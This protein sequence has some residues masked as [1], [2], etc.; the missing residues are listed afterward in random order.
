MRYMSFPRQ[1]ART[2][3]FTLGAPRS[4]QI[5][6]DGTRAA[7]LRSRSGND[8]ATC[9]WVRE[10]G[11]H[12]EWVAADPREL[13]R[14]DEDLPPE[15]RAR[16]ERL[17]ETG[18][19][20]VSY[21]VDDAFT[22]AVFTLSG[23]LY[24]VDLAGGDPRE[25]P[26]A[27]PVVD[28]VLCPRG[29]S[30]AYVSGGAVHV[31]ALGNGADL[32]LAEP[33]GEHVTW[34]LADFIASEEMGRYHGMWWSP[35]SSAVLAARVDD[36]AVP[37]W[38]IADPAHPEAAARTI[39]YPAAGTENADVRLAILPADGEGDRV[40]I[41][42]NRAALPYLV[43]AGWT[44][45]PEGTPTVVFSA[46][47]RDQRT[48]TVF[49]ADPVTGLVFELH[50]ETDEVW[51][52]IM[53]GV[54][55]FCG[56]ALLWI[57][58]RAGDRER[59]LYLGGDAVTPEGLYLRGVVSVDGDRVLFSASESGA[60]EST[61]LWLLDVKENHLKPVEFP[62]S[63]GTGGV[64]AGRLRGDT[65]VHQRRDLE[66]DGVVT[67]VTQGASSE[68]R[69]VHT[70]VTSHAETPDLPTPRVTMWRAGER[71]IPAALVLPSW[72]EPGSGRLP[73]LLDPYGGPHAQRVVSAR[74]AFLTSQW[75]ADQGFAVLIADGRGTPGIGVQW[76][77][78]VHGDL[79]GPVLE[80]QVA[81]LHDALERY[82]DLDPD[83]VAIRGWSFGG[84]LAALAV[85]R[86]PDVFH[87]AISGAPVTD[88]RLYDTHYTERYL[89]HPAT[90]V[91]AY[92]RSSVIDDAAHLEGRL[93]LI[94][95]YVDDNVVYAHTQRLSS[96][97]LAAGKAHTVLP[98]SGI[99]HMASEE[100]TAENLLLL[101]VAFLRE[102][103]PSGAAADTAVGG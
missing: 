45:G 24:C 25:L 28:P 85:L 101:Q 54:P 35:D 23:R 70:A 37:R 41:E 68:T 79:A 88:Q 51:V 59:R 74:S 102:T 87:A 72:Y 63:N 62:T 29:E 14:V 86:R 92:T 98:L 13:G 93:M 49:S 83:R 65:L 22:R 57:G 91:A 18:S 4:F 1:Q 16:R 9:L 43:T 11:G 73:V 89:G 21:T 2:R 78:A 27:T 32:T 20:I 67:M 76:E 52:E 39:A 30:V 15:E 3:R 84:F 95:G 46:Q 81:V 47:S 26:A 80:D 99:T 60:P 33:D 94:H 5:S 17:R 75:F 6:P 66:T 36:S 31:L 10:L 34:G 96:A 97:L 71:R 50:T 58:R 69:Q 64:H 82:D 55:D 103:F 56:G 42:W 19:G 7:F 44:T 77:Q 40:P 48:L 61:G 12:N 90:E 100:T 53:P 8:T 38:T